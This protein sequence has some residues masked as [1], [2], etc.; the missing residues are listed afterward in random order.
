MVVYFFE[1]LVG[2]FG[3]EKVFG[4]VG[5]GTDYDRDVQFV[6]VTQQFARGV[7]VVVAF[8]VDAACVDFGNAARFADEFDSLVHEVEIPFV[9]L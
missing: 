9:V 2:T 6:H 3:A 1:K 8:L 7:V 5:V 4:C